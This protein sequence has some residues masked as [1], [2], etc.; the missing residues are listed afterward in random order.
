MKKIDKNYCMS[1]FLTF[2]YVDNN[3]IIFKEGL[4]H[5]LFLEEKY[6]N[7]YDIVDY[8]DVENALQD[9]INKEVDGSTAIFLS[10]GIDSAIVASFLKPGTKAYTFKCIA[11][12]AK[13]ETIFSKKYAEKYGLDLEIIEVTWED[14]LKY[15][16]ALMK[17]QNM[18][19]HSIGPQIYKA[20]LR[21]KEEGINK[22]ITGF[23]ADDLF[24]GLDKILSKDRTLQEFIDWYTHVDPKKVLKNSVSMEKTFKKYVKPDGIVDAE[25]VIHEGVLGEEGDTSFINPFKLAN[26]KRIA[27]YTRMNL[28]NK[29]DINRIRNGEPKYLLRQVFK[30]RYPEFDIPNKVPLP[31]AVDQWLCNWKGPTRNEFKENCITGFN[32]DQK[33]LL[34]SLELF[35]NINDIDED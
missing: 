32:G 33:W 5:E 22:I 9:I 30:D 25:K 7:K 11:D 18:P 8:K 31:R 17:N 4:E 2:R 26:M 28:V 10:G 1:S 29:L 15:T 21:A 23:G 12:G 20:L 16:P 27:T 19:I 6:D 13:D 14:Y 34:Y 3:D 24:G 35:L